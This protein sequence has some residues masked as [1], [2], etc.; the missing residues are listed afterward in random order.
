LR[1]KAAVVA[2]GV[3][4]LQELL[5]ETMNNEISTVDLPHGA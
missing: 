1:Y 4:L 5:E 2:E 3:E